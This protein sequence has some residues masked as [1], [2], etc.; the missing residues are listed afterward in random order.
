MDKRMLTLAAR[1]EQAIKAQGVPI[2]GV[3]LG[4]LDD[5]STWKV[6]PADLQA[7]A[8][9]HINAF[10]EPTAQQIADE[11][12]TREVDSKLLRAVVRELWE[13]IPVPKPTLAA[14][15]QRIIDRYKS[16]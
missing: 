8:Q 4:R 15:R 9:P 12:A 5:R 1:V 6:V 11:D 3:S 13:I 14:L 16:L 10:V 2:T 7:A